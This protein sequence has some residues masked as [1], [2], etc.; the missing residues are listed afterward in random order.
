MSFD[1]DSKLL[2]W[3]IRMLVLYYQVISLKII[4]IKNFKSFE[5]IFNLNTVS[6]LRFFLLICKSH[7]TP[8]MVNISNHWLMLVFSWESLSF[9]HT[10]LEVK[11]GMEVFSTV[12][13]RKIR[14]QNT[15]EYIVHKLNIYNVKE[16][17][18]INL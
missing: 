18:L 14:E 17:W 8:S 5:W 7:R 10:L 3:M 2:L 15:H 6:Q 12:H 11:S 13:D 9:I 16:C 4:H 1:Q